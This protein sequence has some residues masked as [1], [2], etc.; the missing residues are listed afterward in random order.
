MH[1]RIASEQPEQ[2]QKRQRSSTGRGS[3]GSGLTHVD[4]MGGGENEEVPEFKK[5]T[6]AQKELWDLY[7]TSFVFG[8]QTYPVD[9]AQCIMAK[10][11]YIIKK[12]EAKIVKSV[13]V[14]VIQ[15]EDIL[16]R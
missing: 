8:M 16:Q 1:S 2:P 5:F 9:I 7:M 10:D 6:A 12:M 14:E 3:S 15:M 13:K 11:E 4:N